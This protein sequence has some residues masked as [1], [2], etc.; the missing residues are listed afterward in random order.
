MRFQRKI[1]SGAF[2]KR[3]EKICSCK[4]IIII[5]IRV[6]HPILGV[7]SLKYVLETAGTS[8]RGEKQTTW[9]NAAK[10]EN[11]QRAKLATG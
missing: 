10:V 1:K 2:F 6:F 7:F 3:K 9:I 8:K 11:R 5:I 4:I